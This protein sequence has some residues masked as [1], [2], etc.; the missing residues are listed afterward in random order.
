MARRRS[1]SRRSASRLPN[2]LFLSH[3]T[4]DRRFADRL[5]TVLRAHG[6]PVWYS[7]T[8]LLGAQQWHDEIGAALARCD[9][10][11]VILSPSAV[12][13]RWV[14]RELMY[15]LTDLRNE[16]RILPLMYKSCDLNQ[17]SWTLGSLQRIDFTE[18]FDEGARVMLRT[19]GVGYRGADKH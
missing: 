19:W 4:P 7:R 8:N 10:F 11:A 14:K 2:E 15:A 3:A 5:A 16:T 12:R 9:W 6:V 13:S 1:T 18:D 17:L